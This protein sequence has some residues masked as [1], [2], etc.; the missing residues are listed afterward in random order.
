MTRWCL[1][2]LF[3]VSI[4]AR[5]APVSLNESFNDLATSGWTIVNA[6]SPVR[7]DTSADELVPG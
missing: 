4:G 1:L 7:S 2:G 6:S 5:A 3:I